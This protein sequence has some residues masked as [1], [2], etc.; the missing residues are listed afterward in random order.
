MTARNLTLIVPFASV[1]GDLCNNAD[2]PAA[3]QFY[4]LHTLLNMSMITN[5]FLVPKTID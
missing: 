1:E 2:A 5:Q 4:Q 3:S